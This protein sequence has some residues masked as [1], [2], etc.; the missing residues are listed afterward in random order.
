MIN[1]IVA[2]PAAAFAGIHDG[3]TVMISAFGTAGMP[4]QP[5]AALIDVT[6]ER[7]RVLDMVDGLSL[8]ELAKLTGVPLAMA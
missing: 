7:L 4:S 3:A 5:I 1:K 6:H 2:T 8:T